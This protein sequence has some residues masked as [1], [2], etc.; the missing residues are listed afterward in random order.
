MH[1]VQMCKILLHSNC[2]FS[3]QCILSLNGCTV[4]SFL[5][6]CCYFFFLKKREK[7][8]AMTVRHFFL[9]RHVHQISFDSIGWPIIP[10]YYWS[11]EKWIKYSSQVQWREDWSF[12]SLASPPDFCLRIWTQTQCLWRLAS[13]GPGRKEGARRKNSPECKIFNLIGSRRSCTNMVRRIRQPNRQ[14]AGQNPKP[15]SRQ[16]EKNTKSLRHR[17]TNTAM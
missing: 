17:D 1:A 13:A 14:G 4:S 15:R 8:V 7:G 2:M 12:F 16:G 10:S 9:F 5:C 6:F 3:L 11:L